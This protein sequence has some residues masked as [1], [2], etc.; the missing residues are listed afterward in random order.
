VN[1]ILHLDYLV[2]PEMNKITIT[3]CLDLQTI[4]RYF[5]LNLLTE[6]L[7]NPTNL[8]HVEIPFD[9]GQHYEKIHS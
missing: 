3:C 6:M 9:I 2:L 4:S 7:E 5:L 8:E 1:R